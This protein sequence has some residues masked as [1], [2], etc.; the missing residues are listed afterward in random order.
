MNNDE[1]KNCGI[2]SPIFGNRS[3]NSGHDLVEIL[4]RIIPIPAICK[5]FDIVDKNVNRR[6]L[7]IILIPI[8]MGKIITKHT[9]FDGQ[10]SLPKQCV[11]NFLTFVP[12]N[13]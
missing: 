8:T 2:F 13:R 4:Y 6:I 7:R 12:M 1:T 10:F 5:Q 9:S 11:K 3:G